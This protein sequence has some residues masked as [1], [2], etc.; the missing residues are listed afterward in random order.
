MDAKIPTFSGVPFVNITIVADN[1]AILVLDCIIIPLKV[2]DYIEQNMM[3]AFTIE[4]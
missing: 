3:V 2:Q 4:L 1:K